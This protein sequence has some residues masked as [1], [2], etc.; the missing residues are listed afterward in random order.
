MIH[1]C[2]KSILQL[3]MNPMRIVLIN[4]THLVKRSRKCNRSYSENF[5]SN[6]RYRIG[7][8]YSIIYIAVYMQQWPTFVYTS[9]YAAAGAVIS[10]QRRHKSWHTYLTINTKLSIIISMRSCLAAF[11]Q[12]CVSM[13]HKIYTKGMVLCQTNSFD[14]VYG[15][16]IDM[17]NIV[18]MYVL[19]VR[20][21]RTIC[22]IN[23][24]NEYLNTQKM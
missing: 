2:I 17:R 15:I 1:H 4:T 5:E 14:G 10:G 18:R 19:Y 13:I 9:C 3:F 16:E 23:I 12:I 6:S 8:S 11:T 21:Q 24:V 20:L 22:T 7:N